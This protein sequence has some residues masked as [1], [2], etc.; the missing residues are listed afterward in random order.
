MNL[1]ETFAGVVRRWY[2]FLVGLIATAGLA[3]GAYQYVPPTYEASG[4]ILLMPSEA[5]VGEDGNPYLFLGGMTEALDV[6]IRRSNAAEIQ[7]S[8]LKRFDGASYTIQ[9]DRMTSSPIVVVS[10][11]APSNEVALALLQAAMTTVDRNLDSMQNELSV[12][13]RKRIHA[14]ELVVDP[15]A[16]VNSKMQIQ[17]A[18]VA[19]G[20]GVLGTFM[21]TGFM[22]GLLNQRRLRKDSGSINEKAQIHRGRAAEKKSTFVPSDSPP[23][24]DSEVPRKT[25]RSSRLTRTP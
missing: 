11:E 1:A 25:I 7:E 21:L 13:P 16:T 23:T 18:I 20:G 12:V 3:W 9:P 19:V 15:E 5:T 8:L 4:S 22:D 2:I 24:G 17:L 10:V 14:K 6:L